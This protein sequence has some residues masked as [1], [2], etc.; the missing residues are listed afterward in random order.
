MSTT[1]YFYSLYN[2]KGDSISPTLFSKAK[3][4]SIWHGKTLKVEFEPFL[5]WASTKEKNNHILEFIDYLHEKT[6]PKPKKKKVKKTKHVSLFEKPPKKVKDKSS[7]E[8][9]YELRGKRMK[10]YKPNEF[11]KARYFSLFKDDKEVEG[12]LEWPKHIKRP[13]H[14]KQYVLDYVT[15]LEDEDLEIRT[16]T[17]RAKEHKRTQELLNRPITMMNDEYVVR[18]YVK[19]VVSHNKVMD[20]MRVKKFDIKYK[21]P[22]EVD[23][24]DDSSVDES[25]LM[26][27]KSFNEFFPVILEDALENSPDDFQH[28]FMVAVMLPKIAEDTS[29]IKENIIASF[30]YDEQ[31]IANDFAS[32]R[33]NVDVVLK[34]TDNS[35]GQRVLKWLVLKEDV[36]SQNI[37]KFKNQFASDAISAPRFS[38]DSMKRA[39]EHFDK[40]MENF[41][42]KSN[43]YLTRSYSTMGV[44]GGF[45]IEYVLERYMK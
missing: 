17:K 4:F 30:G 9:S 40:I 23:P 15:Y 6:R 45:V 33:N 12:Y 34:Y 21:N 28:V 42:K 14:K 36:F 38:A 27:K 7:P 41:R 26:M 10:L 25:I 20:K 3:Y 29:T 13:L 5:P 24:M 8:F 19:E 1:D 35:E 16:T 11:S 18:E 43:E 32:K 31:H 2:S 44:I 37:K 22:I 39:N